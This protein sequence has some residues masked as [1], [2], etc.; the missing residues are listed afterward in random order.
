MTTLKTLVLAKSIAAALIASAGIAAPTLS[1][2][3]A[4]EGVTCASDHPGQFANGVFKC[5]KPDPQTRRSVCLPTLSLSTISVDTCRVP[6][7][8]PEL[9]AVS[10]SFAELVATDL[11]VPHDSPVRVTS[12]IARDSF[13]VLFHDYKFPE[14]LPFLGLPDPIGHGIKCP[15]GATAVRSNGGNTLRCE[16]ARENAVCLGLYILKQ[17]DSKDIC[18][19]EVNGIIVNQQ[20]TLP[21]G[22]LLSIGWTLDINGAPG[23]STRDQWVRYV[24]ATNFF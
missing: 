13:N 1:Y 20:P 2:A 10:L 17:R 5:H 15:N 14:G 8:P 12:N 7:S 21:S 23:G 3:G 11:V 18:A 6:N 9:P 4:A 22:Q 19:I 24:D 16:A